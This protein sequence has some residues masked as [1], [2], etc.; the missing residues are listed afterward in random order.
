MSSL[1]LV[2]NPTIIAVQA[3]VFLANF[4]IVKKLYL[5]PYLKLTGK[6]E[7]MTDGSQEESA[8]IERK[9]AET[10]AQMETQLRELNEYTHEYRL[11]LNAEADDKS[12]KILQSAEKESESVLAEI[13]EEIKLAVAKESANIPETVEELTSAIYKQTLSV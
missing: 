11:R 3:G 6:R 4:V 13:Q 9:N 7:G 5:D 2:P 8:S 12:A 1:H 10:S